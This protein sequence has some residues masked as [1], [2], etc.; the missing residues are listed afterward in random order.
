MGSPGPRK[1]NV[2]HLNFIL[3]RRDPKKKT[4]TW[5]VRGNFGA[6][7]GK[8]SWYSPWRRYV[9]YPEWGSLFDGECCMTLA[10]FLNG[11]TAAHKK[12][13]DDR[14]EDRE[15]EARMKLNPRIGPGPGTLG[16]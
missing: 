9:F 16:P 5:E 1:L 2:D 6:V 3:G 14:I 7:L 10:N 13:R 12:A 15:L 11:A 4:D 8:V